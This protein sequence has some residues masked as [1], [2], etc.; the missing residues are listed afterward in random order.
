MHAYLHRESREIRLA[1]EEKDDYREWQLSVPE[2]LRLIALLG[3]ACQGK[4]NLVEYDHQSA[5]EELHRRLPVG[6]IVDA[7]FREARR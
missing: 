7:E 4:L 6:E 3:E 5:I 1:I 2:A